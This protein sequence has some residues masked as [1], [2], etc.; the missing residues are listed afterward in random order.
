MLQEG[1]YKQ[2]RGHTDKWAPPCPPA[3]PL[4]IPVVLFFLLIFYF[5][6]GQLPSLQDVDKIICLESYC[7]V[8]WDDINA[9]EST[10]H[11]IA[12]QPML[13]G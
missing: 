8:S 3:A 9:Q 13:C 11:A 12:S 5:S 10:R 2:Y 4:P 7:R 6:L 1:Q